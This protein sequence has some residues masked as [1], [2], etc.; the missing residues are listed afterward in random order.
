MVGVNGDV[1]E[2]MRPCLTVEERKHR[3]EHV[4]VVSHFLLC[5]CVRVCV[6]NLAPHKDME[7]RKS[8]DLQHL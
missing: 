1:R 6:Y 5:V 7:D 3:D 4:R 8:A 2:K